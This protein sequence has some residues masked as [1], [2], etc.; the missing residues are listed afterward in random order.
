MLKGV[1]ISSAEV[2][3]LITAGATLLTALAMLVQNEVKR[4]RREDSER[5]DKAEEEKEGKC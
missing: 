4:R 1:E 2:G 5:A 3:V